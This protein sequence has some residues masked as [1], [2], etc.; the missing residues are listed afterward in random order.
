MGMVYLILDFPFLIIFVGYPIYFL[1]VFNPP[2]NFNSQLAGS[3]SGRQLDFAPSERQEGAAASSLSCNDSAHSRPMQLSISSSAGLK[4]G[5]EGF[6]A[7]TTKMHFW[8]GL[9]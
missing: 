5:S 1:V 8:H 9:N 2:L 4:L 7:E 3:L 6:S